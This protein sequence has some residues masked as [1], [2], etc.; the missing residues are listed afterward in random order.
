MR[1]V[2]DQ[3]TYGLTADDGYRIGPARKRIGFMTDSV[4]LAR[5]LEKRCPNKPGKEVHVHVRLE[6][7]RTKTAQ[8][9]PPNYA[10]RF[11]EAL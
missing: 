9:H 8:E 11:A 1:V 3:C 10:E 4:C 7:G 5:Q 6:N 2:G